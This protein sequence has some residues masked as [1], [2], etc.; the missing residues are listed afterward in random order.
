VQWRVWVIT[1]SV[2]QRYASG[3]ADRPDDCV[4]ARERDA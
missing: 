3:D 1:S 2:K 4:L